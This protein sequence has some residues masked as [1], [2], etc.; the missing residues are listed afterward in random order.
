MK[1]GSSKR[2]ELQSDFVSLQHKRK[3]IP[4]VHLQILKLLVLLPMMPVGQQE[5]QNIAIDKQKHLDTQFVFI[6][7]SSTIWRRSHYDKQIF[8]SLG[9]VTTLSSHRQFSTLVGFRA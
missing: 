1:V 4:L 6:C 9:L 7:S 5:D 2:W 8:I 3:N